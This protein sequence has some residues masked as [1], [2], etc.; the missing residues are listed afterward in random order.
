MSFSKPGSGQCRL[1]N[2]EVFKRPAYHCHI[3]RTPARSKRQPQRPE[4]LAFSSMGI[5]GFLCVLFLLHMFGDFVHSSVLGSFIMNSGGTFG[6]SSDEPM[7]KVEFHPE[8]S[9][10]HPEDGQEKIAM[11]NKEGQNYICFLPVVEQTKAFKSFTQDNSSRITME[12][13]QQLK[14]KTPDD[15]LIKVLKD[16]CFYKREG[17]W[18]YEFCFQK[19]VKQLHLEDDSNTVVQEFVLGLFDP[20]ATAAVNHNQSG[21]STLK[22]PHFKDASQRYHPQLYTNGTICDLTNQR[23]ETEIR[24]VCAD[25]PVLI[26]SIKEV[27]TCKYIVTVQSPLL[28]KHPRFQLEKPIWQTIHCNEGETIQANNEGSS[29]EDGTQIAVVLD[30]S[31]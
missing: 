12:T 3:G 9:P 25:P 10:F 15:E 22:D 1:V 8:H 23:R 31:A 30:D 6:R 24:F 20:N 21:I 14:F 5:A 7:F 16:Q 28:C 13:D 19:H 4:P 27:A 29:V 11:L 2:P 26:S 17:W 18:V